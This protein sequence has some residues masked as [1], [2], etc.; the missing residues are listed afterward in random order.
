[1]TTA[2]DAHL[3]AKSSLPR[4]LLLGALV[5][6]L[7]ALWHVTPLRV[8]LDRERVADLG[9]AIA[10]RRDAPLLVLVVYLVAGLA[11]CPITP[12]LAATA[13]VFDPWRAL[14]LGLGGAL[15]SAALGYGIGRL[16][17]RRRPRWIESARIAPLRARLRRRGVLAMAAVRLVPAGNFTLANVTAGALGIPLPDYLVGNALGLLPVL[18]ALT[19]LSRDLRHLWWLP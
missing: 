3:A 1:M 9:R 7:I 12:L 5:A 17:G 2:P 14:G 8:L 18:L 16:V 6:A 11:L 15:S 13:L 19:V 4:W 10:A